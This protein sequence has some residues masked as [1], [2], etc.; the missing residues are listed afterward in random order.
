MSPALRFARG[1]EAT[2]SLVAS[3]IDDGLGASE[4]PS[5]P[6]NLLFIVFTA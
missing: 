3:G 1:V 5:R 4:A 6:W 2:K